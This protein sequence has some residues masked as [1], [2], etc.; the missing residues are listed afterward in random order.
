MFVI[1]PLLSLGFGPLAFIALPVMLLVVAI[2]ALPLFL[3]LRKWEKL[4]WWHVVLGGGICTLIA[5]WVYFDSA[6]PSHAHFAGPSN[7]AL[8][9]A[10]GLAGSTV[11]WWLGIFK[12]KELAFVS[13]SPPYGMVV[14][15]PIVFGLIYYHT[16]M[17]PVAGPSGCIEAQRALPQPTAWRFAEIEV[18]FPADHIERFSLTQGD[19]QTDH[20]GQCVNSWRRP[21]AS[22][23]GTRYLYSGVSDG[24]CGIDC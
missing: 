8:W 5:T 7:T 13:T 4:D 21:T 16:I 22:L 18:R 12:N 24:R 1:P 20:I 9:L 2:L 15:L 3:L 14:V 17:V 23:T 19:A 6:N 11:Y 10:I